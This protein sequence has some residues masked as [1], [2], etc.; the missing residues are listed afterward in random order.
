MGLFERLR[1]ELI[2]II[3]WIDPTNDTLAY[4][5]E[6]YNN[7][8][9]MGA[10]LIVRPGQ[11]AVFV[12]EGQIADSFTPGTYELTTQ[13][14][15]ILSTLRGWKYGFKSPFKA[16]VYFFSTRLFTNLKWGTP[17]VITVR[18]AELGMLQIRAFG[19]YNIRVA[20]PARL[21]EELIST[22]GHFQV[23]EISDYLRN[24][25]ISD[26]ATAVGRSPIP[27]VD[28]AARYREL[29]DTLCAEM[30]ED[31]QRLGLELTQVLIESVSLP[32]DVQEAVNKRVSMNVLGNMQQYAQYQ[33]AQAVE[34][35]AN[36]PGG[37]NMALDFGVGIAFG[38]QLAQ[39][40]QAPNTAPPAAP[41]PAVAQAP[42]GQAPMGQPPT[43][44]PPV[45]QWFISRNGENL[46]PF[47]AEQL[48]QQGLT[49]QTYVWRAGMEGWSRAAEVP[50]LAAI[51]AA[52]PPSAPES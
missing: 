39:S 37:G 16:E 1:G 43:P 24:I 44:P 10:K 7:E 52:I 6:R 13:N 20:N 48:G 40:L 31:I 47:L 8:I 17:N 35:S 3:E 45:V 29:G 21:L 33:A 15:P 30:Q 46:G 32:P 4:R 49:A 2:D 5:F 19:T 28:F 34:A 22:D 26:F 11:A 38:Q 12:N 41:P 23:D 36:N 14:L 27:F 51:L 9:K 25:L 50:E 18:D 42:M